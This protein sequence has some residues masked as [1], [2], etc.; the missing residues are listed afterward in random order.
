MDVNKVYT[1]EFEDEMK[2]LLSAY[3]EYKNKKEC[4]CFHFAKNPSE[5]LVRPNMQHR[6]D[7]VERNIC[8]K[9]VYSRFISKL[10][11]ARDKE[12]S[13]GMSPY[14]NKE[15]WYGFMEDIQQYHD[16]NKHLNT[17]LET[18]DASI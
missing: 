13:S 14:N 15:F 5:F 18:V 2:S 17:E 12:K 3:K 11:W 9:D 10:K 1:F 6:D 16:D 8:L 4:I 7:E